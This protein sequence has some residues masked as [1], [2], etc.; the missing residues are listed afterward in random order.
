MKIPIS[1]SQKT[2]LLKAIKAGE[3]DSEI[4][5]ELKDL[6]PVKDE[7]KEL[8]DHGIIDQRDELCR[9]TKY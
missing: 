3:F 2:E 9:N 7:L 6:K 8:I 5:P 4:F 1:K